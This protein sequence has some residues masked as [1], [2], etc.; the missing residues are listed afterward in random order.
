MPCFTRVERVYSFGTQSSTL[1]SY[2]AYAD[3]V[4]KLFHPQTIVFI[5][6]GNDFDESLLKYKNE[7]GHSYFVEEAI[8]QSNLYGWF[9]NLAK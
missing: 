1:S 4:A 2:L 5:I 8:A 7:P 3:Y 9:R 6:I